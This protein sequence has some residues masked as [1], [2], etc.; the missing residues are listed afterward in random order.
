MSTKSHEVVLLAGPGDSTRIVYSALSRA[1]GL[2]EI[3]LEDRVDRRQL[4]RRRMKKLG[5]S[6]ALSQ[7][8]FATTTVPALNLVSRARLRELRQ[9]LSADDAPIPAGA[10]TRVPSVNSTEC[11]RWLELHRPKVV[12]V[13]GTRIIA[14]EVLDAIPAVFLN[15]HAGITPRYRGV[16][17]AYWA[18]AEKRPEAAG[19]TVHLVDK[20]IDTGSI[21]AQAVIS[22]TADDTFVTL[23]YLQLQAGIP[24]LIAA[25]RQALEG[26]VGTVPSLDSADSKLWYHPTLGEYFGNLVRGGAR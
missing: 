2:R 15:M 11:I 24:L 18:Q 19:V 26:P 21:V 13:N 6:R 17:G 14:K 12:V 1:V 8:L 20:G 23:P 9:R 7:A 3:V 25:V 16:H 4:L 10:I 22:P 5:W